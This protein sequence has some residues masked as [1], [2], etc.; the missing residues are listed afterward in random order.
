MRT[1]IDRIHDVSVD[2]TV[3]ISRMLAS[4]ICSRYADAEESAAD[5]GWS[6]A[7]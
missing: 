5:G 2:R 1:A 7:T 4:R 6:C 3:F